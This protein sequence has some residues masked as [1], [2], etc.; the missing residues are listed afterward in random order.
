VYGQY[1]PRTTG[2]VMFAILRL[3]LITVLSSKDFWLGL[4][5]LGR[6]V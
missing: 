6:K 4:F 5:W 1:E 3:N 2:P